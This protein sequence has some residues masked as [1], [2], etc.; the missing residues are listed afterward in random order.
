MRSCFLNSTLSEADVSAVGVA[1]RT[2]VDQAM[3]RWTSELMAML[4][5][6]GAVPPA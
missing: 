4:T 6:G 2:E 1:V 3:Q 5:K